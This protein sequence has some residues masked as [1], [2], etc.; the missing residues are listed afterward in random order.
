MLEQ[1][2]RAVAQVGDQRFEPAHAARIARFFL[3]LFH[4]TET[5]QRPQPGVFRAH[6]QLDVLLGFHLDVKPHLRI[7]A[8]VELAMPKQRVQSFPHA[9]SRT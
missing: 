4:R 1:R 2:A 9:M 6:A 5:P 3:V 7:E 8:A